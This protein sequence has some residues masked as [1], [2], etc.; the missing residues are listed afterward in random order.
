MRPFRKFVLLLVL[1]FAVS[2]FVQ[3]Q[4]GSSSPNPD[5]QPVAGE[6]Q[7]V[8]LEHAK[9]E[10]HDD[11]SEFKES[12]SVQWIAQHTGMSVRNAYWVLII[13]NFVIIAG[14]IVWGWKKNVP[15]IFKARSEAIRKQ[16]EEAR[17]ASEDANR[18]LSDIEQ[19]LSR[20]DSEISD[21]RK[22][23][24]EE[25]AAE[26]QR[27]RAA[28][29][30]ERVKVIESAE[31][32]IDAAAKAARRDLKAFAASLAVDLAEKKIHVDSNTDQALV[33]RFVREL[34]R[35]GGKGGR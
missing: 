31:Q 33:G 6:Q 10:E 11:H 18:R 17:R 21:M 32:E 5:Q 30:E 7:P 13:A 28:A 4:N 24:E 27:I 23:S 25:V 26:E 20:L 12:P 9:G 19:R 3:G 15:A 22:R 29:E 34:G 1:M 2:G 16:L 14:L 8:P 35:N